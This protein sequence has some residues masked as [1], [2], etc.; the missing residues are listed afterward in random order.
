ML[1]AFT[2]EKL[3]WLRRYV[4]C[5]DVLSIFCLLPFLRADVGG[6]KTP[7]FVVLAGVLLCEVEE[8]DW[9]VGRLMVDN[10]L[11]DFVCATCRHTACFPQ[12]VTL[13]ILVGRVGVTNDREVPRL[14]QNLRPDGLTRRSICMLRGY[15]M[16][17]KRRHALM[18]HYQMVL[19]PR[20]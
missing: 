12:S 5:Q 20:R 19:V 18:L 17:W 8:L 6:P 14:S 4:A 9:F 10:K 15:D 1:L 16:L 3:A 11:L 13:Q 7:E 2:P